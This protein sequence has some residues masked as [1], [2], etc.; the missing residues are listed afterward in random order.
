MPKICNVSKAQLARMIVEYK[1]GKS[2]EAL[3]TSLG[4]SAGTVAARLQK[5]GVKLRAPGFKVGKDHH[6]WKGG[7]IEHEGYLQVLIYPDDP[8]YVMAKVK[9]A[10]ANGGRYVLEHRYKMAKK[11]KRCLAEHE[12]VHHKDGN[13]LNNNLHNLQLRQG[14]H[15]KGSSFRCCNCGSYNVEATALAG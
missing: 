6:A 13:T 11:L 4:I 15:G 12:T 8:Y 2:T 7:R 10:S 14:N 3:G 5:A 1:E 9:S